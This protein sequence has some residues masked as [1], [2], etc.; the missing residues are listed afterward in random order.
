VERRQKRERR[1]QYVKNSQWSSV[2]A[3]PKSAVE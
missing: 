3:N 1:D 2:C